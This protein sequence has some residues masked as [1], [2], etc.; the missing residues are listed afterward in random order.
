MVGDFFKSKSPL[1]YYTEKAAELITWLRG[2][3]RILDHLPYAVIRPVLTRWTAHYMAYR[4]LLLMY[5]NLRSLVLMEHNK[6]DEEKLFDIGDAASKA[7]ARKM[8]TIIKDN[9]FWHNIAL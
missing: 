6:S 3:I 8:V 4:R 2:K 1:L 5:G 9:A 7:K